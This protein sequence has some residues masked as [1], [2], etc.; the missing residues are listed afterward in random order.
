MGKL[1]PRGDN[2]TC[3]KHVSQGQQKFNPST[4]HSFN[5]PNQ[6][7]LSQH[8]LCA[9]YC[10]GSWGVMGS[11]WSFLTYQERQ[12]SKKCGEHFKKN[13]RAFCDHKGVQGGPHPPQ[14]CAF[15]LT[16][17]SSLGCRRCVREDPHSG[18]R[19]HHAGGHGHLGG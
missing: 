16:S 5:Q 3:L 19:G 13:W 10:A 15:S 12:T 1:R 11:S 9:R 2:V 18:W 8:L 7:K 6:A 14:A 4:P 17:S